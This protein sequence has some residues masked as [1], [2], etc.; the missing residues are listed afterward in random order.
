MAFATATAHS[1]H[2]KKGMIVFGVTHRDDVVAGDAKLLEGDHLSA[3]L[4]DAGRKQ[5]DSL[6]VEDDLGFESDFANRFEGDRLLRTPERN[7][8]LAHA[9]SGKVSHAQSIHECW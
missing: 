3:L 8:D 5:H 1:E 4:I 2:R 9:Q 7:G 6:F